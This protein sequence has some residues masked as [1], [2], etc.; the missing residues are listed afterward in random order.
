VNET[1]LAVAQSS[2]SSSSFYVEDPVTIVYA[3]GVYVDAFSYRLELSGSDVQRIPLNDFRGV[4]SLQGSLNGCEWPPEIPPT[5]QFGGIV[6]H[7]FARPG[8]YSATF[9]VS[10]RVTQNGNEESVRAEVTITVSTRPSLQVPN[11]IYETTVLT[12]TSKMA[13]HLL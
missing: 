8:V 2:S 9:T 4:D 3:V 13:G 5:G 1:Y 11:V 10:G 7:R 12:R 6:V